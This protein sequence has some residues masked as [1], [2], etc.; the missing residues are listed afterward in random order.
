MAE[1]LE[2]GPV[3]HFKLTVTDPT[4]SRDFYTGLFGFQVVGEFGPVILIGNGSVMIGLG[5]APAPTPATAHDRFDENRVG[6]DHLSFGVTNREALDQA[7]RIFDQR[8][9]PHGEIMDLGEAFG[10][11]VLVFRDPDNIQMELTAPRGE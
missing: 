7:V 6:L 5:P 4:R 3:H 2:L 10:L 9:V 8:G 11:C 1:Q